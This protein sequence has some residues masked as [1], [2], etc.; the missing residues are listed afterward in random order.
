MSNNQHNYPKV[1]KPRDTSYST[2]QFIL[3]EIGK[4]KLYEI[5]K[6]NGHRKT[7]KILTEKLDR[8]ISPMVIQYIA[9]KKFSWVRVV[10]DK[11]LSIYKAV[12]SGKVDRK[13]YRTIVF[14]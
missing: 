7:A 10:C 14:K 13:H 5:W 8:Y 4:D 2:T 6:E 12:L 11:S 1:R 9:A 3:K